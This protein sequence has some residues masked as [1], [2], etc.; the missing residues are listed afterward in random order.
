MLWPV[1]GVVGAKGTVE[2][3]ENKESD[4]F[5]ANSG[6]QA[7]LGT[8]RT[9]HG[10]MF[11]G[12]VPTSMPPKPPWMLSAEDG[13]TDVDVGLTLGVRTHGRCG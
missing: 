2:E 1:F 5:P 7:T 10:E 8:L 4:T 13:V 11:Y 12:V 6:P 9:R 3:G